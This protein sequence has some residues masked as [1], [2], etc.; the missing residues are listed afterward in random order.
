M[1]DPASAQSGHGPR[2]PGCC[3]CW[4]RGLLL[5]QEVPC[6]EK[7]LEWAPG[8]G[9]GRRGQGGTWRKPSQA[10]SKGRN[11]P[12]L[13]RRH[14]P[15]KCPPTGPTPQ[16]RQRA[17]ARALLRARPAGLTASSPVGCGPGALTPPRSQG[18]ARARAGV[19]VSPLGWR[20]WPGSWAGPR[21]VRGSL[22]G[23]GQ[24]GRSQS[25]PSASPSCLEQGW[26]LHS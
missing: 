12:C 15:S 26:S 1:A 4:H 23:S 19:L 24:A 13:G 16:R 9:G 3:L 17:Q 8:R 11:Q 6:S 14:T 25:H 10:Q 22:L 7:V 21:A 20:W 18:W 2:V 5:K